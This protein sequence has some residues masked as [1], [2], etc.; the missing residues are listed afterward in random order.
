MVAAHI[1]FAKAMAQR[2]GDWDT[3]DRDEVISVAC[4]ALCKAAL[5]YDQSSGRFTT[6][7]TNR[8]I[9][10]IRDTQKAARRDKRGGVMDAPISL[11]APATGSSSPLG[12]II[13]H[14]RDVCREVETRIMMGD[15][16]RLL[17]SLEWDVL[18]WLLEG[19]TIREIAS[20]A[21]Y[22]RSR[23]MQIKNTI[24][25]KIREANVL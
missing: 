25:Q 12:H 4:E 2:F 13:P 6:Y 14:S 5:T 21:G 18:Y 3:G 20:M 16:R 24:R 1:G 11:D 9:W 7:A 17:N 22:S 23:V 15:I 19:Y 10:A 8:V